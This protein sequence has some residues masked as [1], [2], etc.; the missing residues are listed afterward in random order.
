[1]V[2]ALDTFDSPIDMRETAGAFG[3]QLTPVAALVAEDVARAASGM[4]V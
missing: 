2:A 4:H 3:V 1:V